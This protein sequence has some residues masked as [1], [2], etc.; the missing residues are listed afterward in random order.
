MIT[1][2]GD[3]VSELY[4]KA[5]NAL[6]KSG[7]ELSP[8]GKLIKELRPVC[9]EF[10]NPLNRVTFV[11]GRMINPFFQLAEALWIL[12]GRSDV[13]WLVKYNANMGQFSD[14]GV[15]FNAP[16]GERLRTWN[17]SRANDF[18]FNPIDQLHDVYAKI[19]QD[20]ET[21]QAVAVI[22]NPMFDN[23]NYTGHGGKDIPCNLILTFK[24]RHDS[25]DLTVFNRSNDVHWG[26]FGANLVQFATIQ[27]LVASWLGLQVG[28]YRQITDSLHVY[29]DDYG[30]KC[31]DL[32]VEKYPSLLTGDKTP[33][34]SNG[35]G[36]INPRM[37]MDINK[38]DDQLMRYWAIIDPV[39]GDDNSMGNSNCNLDTI[40]EL[41]GTLDDEYLKLTVAAMFTYRL[42]K[43]ER[44]DVMFESFDLIAESQWKLSCLHFLAGK[45]IKKGFNTEVDNLISKYPV[46]V[47]NYILGI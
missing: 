28:T 19:T 21:R 38:T 37:G 25:L 6:F 39:L 34:V 46:E 18:I 41:L 40:K 32:M 29:L 47:R 10:T 4:L 43:L 27:E 22:Y 42:F 20:K 30:S 31:T 24:V 44:Y 16:Y 13:Q 26:V 5:V 9:F 36:Y 33:E 17:Q 7:E 3:N 23:F 15:Y 8:R 14:D 1:F 45:L 2:T 11:R 12:S 35:F